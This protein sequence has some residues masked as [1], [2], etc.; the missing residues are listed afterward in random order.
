L[1]QLALQKRLTG[2]RSRHRHTPGLL[3]RGAELV[4]RAGSAI[5]WRRDSSAKSEKS[6]YS[7]VSIAETL[8]QTEQALYRT[9]R[10]MRHAPRAFSAPPAR[11]SAN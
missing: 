10:P 5:C 11:R 7:A 3:P 1:Q 8:I 4:N 9:T 6:S 2:G